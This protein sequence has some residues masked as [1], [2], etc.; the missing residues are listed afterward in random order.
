MGFWMLKVQ[1]H[2]TPHTLN[3]NP[4]SSLSPVLLTNL[5]K[6]EVLNSLPPFLSL[7]RIAYRTQGN[8]LLSK[9]KLTFKKILFSNSN[10]EEKQRARYVG[11]GYRVHV[12]L[13]KYITLPALHRWTIL[14]DLRHSLHSHGWLNHW[15]LV[16]N[17]T[18]SPSGRSGI[19][20]KISPL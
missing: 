8:S 11:K 13:S 16:I 15:L 10:M 17:S 12:P 9:Y 14:W 3:A 19:E 1:S 18:S 6:T 20:L 5:L 4:K 7:A 2:K